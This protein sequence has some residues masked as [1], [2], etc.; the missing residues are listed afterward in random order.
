MD[1]VKDINLKE[2]KGLATICMSAGLVM[3]F[4]IWT[5][6]WNLFFWGSYAWTMFPAVPVVIILHELLHGSLLYLYARN[7]KFGFL[8]ML[9]GGIAFYATSPNKL[10]TR[11]QFTAICL[12]PQVIT[13]ATLV[14]VFTLSLPNWLM[15][16]LLS[17]AAV[18]F[19]GGSS[20]FYVLYWVL[21]S[22]KGARVEDYIAGVK[23][24]KEVSGGTN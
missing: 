24:Y 23:I 18:N 14:C 2:N 21:V 11:K 12:I 16:F 3:M 22:P 5:L 19:G 7:V 20:D 4:A 9:A 10:F 8:G 6:K 17:I 13:T 15:M 1:I